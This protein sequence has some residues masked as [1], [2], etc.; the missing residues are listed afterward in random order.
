MAGNV[1]KGFGT[2]FLILLLS[3]VAAF[4]IVCVVMIFQPFKVIMGYKYFTYKETSPFEYQLTSDNSNIDFKNKDMVRINS[5]YANIRI[6]KNPR[7]EGEVAVVFKNNSKGFAR[8]SQNTDFSYSIIETIENG[9]KILDISIV[10]PQ[11]IL[12]FQKDIEIAFYVP[13]YD[14]SNGSHN[15]YG[16]EFVL[17][18]TSGNIYIGNQFA[19]NE[20]TPS[21]DVSNPKINPSDITIQSSSGLIYFYTEIANTSFSNLNVRTKSSYVKMFG[22]IVATSN[23]SLRTQSGY[24]DLQSLGCLNNFDIILSN[25]MLNAKDIVG[26]LNLSIKA[27][28]CD[29]STIY[30]SIISNNS[31]ESATNARINIE[32]VTENVSLPFLGNSRVDI[33]KIGGQAYLEG[34]GSNINIKEVAGACWIKTKSGKIQV[35]TIGNDATIEATS[36]EIVVYYASNTILNSLKFSSTS[37]KIKLYV[38]PSLGYTMNV[39]DTNGQLRTKNVFVEPFEEYSN[40]LYNSGDK[41]IIF[42]SNG[43]IEVSLFTLETE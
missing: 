11:G 8:A 40:P 5:N 43:R 25:G 41:E 24:F 23:L 14:A 26:K 12:F 1:K 36:G 9:K 18:T 37:G 34:D 3:L 39:Y 32:E 10:E 19:I 31:V 22:N 38:L 2:Y 33:K 30:G 35:Y 4:L 17:T 20:I 13:Y 6:E 16:K 28:Q 7:V 27:G 29:I 21:K 15:I 42:K